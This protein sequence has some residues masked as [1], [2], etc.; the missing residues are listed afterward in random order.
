MTLY[1]CKTSTICSLF[2]TLLH[3]CSQTDKSPNRQIIGKELYGRFASHL[4]KYSAETGNSKY[5]S[6]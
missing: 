6:G 1:R 3:K 5:V 4:L 2:Y